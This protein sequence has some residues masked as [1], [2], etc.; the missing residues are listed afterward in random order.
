LASTI[1]GGCDVI[2]EFVA[3]E[4]WP[5]SHGWAP[6]EIVTFNMNWA[7]KEVLFPWFGLQ[8]KEGQSAEDIMVDIEKKVNAMIGESTMN[9]YKPYKNLVKHKRR[10]N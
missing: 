4:V 1:L 2:E 8:L 9:E 3:A 5:F 7:T 10:I 6:T